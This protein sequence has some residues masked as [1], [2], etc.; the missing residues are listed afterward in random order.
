[1]AQYGTLK[2]YNFIST[3]QDGA[4]DVRGASVYGADG[5]KLGKIDDVIFDHT[6]SNIHYVVVDAGGWLSSK[7][8]IV[9]PQQL[10]PSQK[11]EHDFDLNLT[12]DQIQN[13]PAYDEAAVDSDESWRDY[14]GRYQESWVSGA[15]QHREGSDHNITPTPSEMPAQPGSI[16]ST[17]SSEQN[18][19]LS[20]DRVIPAGTDGVTINNTAVGIGGRWSNFEERLRQ[21]RHEIVAGSGG[22]GGGSV[23]G[24]ASER[25]RDEFRKAS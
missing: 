20:A 17:L 19:S 10:Y 12:K 16:G 23:S 2:N 21:R 1:M 25:E 3:D 8:F 9:P 24:T 13:L 11:H 14:E 7:K 22:V 6:S 15:V 18:A 4:D 5:K